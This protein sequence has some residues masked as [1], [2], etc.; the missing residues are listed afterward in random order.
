MIG[1]LKI[2]KSHL[3]D[4]ITGIV[5]VLGL[6]II[7]FSIF[8]ALNTLSPMFLSVVFSLGLVQLI[9]VIPLITWSAKRRIK[10]FTKG[11]ILGALATATVNFGCFLVTMIFF[12]NGAK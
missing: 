5:T 9:Y 3:S 8:L 6:N 7:V 4:A 10:G 12:S 11:L 2:K 1:I